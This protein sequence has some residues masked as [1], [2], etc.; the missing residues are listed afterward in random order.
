MPIFGNDRVG[1]YNINADDIK[2]IDDM[3][4]SGNTTEAV[5]YASKIVGI[6]PNVGRTL[7]WTESA[8]NPNAKSY[9]GAFGLA[10]LM[11]ST[12]KDL[13]VEISDPAQNLLGGLLYYK[14]MLHATGGDYVQ[15]YKGYQSGNPKIS[16]SA[17]DNFH[18]QGVKNF[19]SKLASLGVTGKADVGSTASSDNSL[20]QLY[21]QIN[22]GISDAVSKYS[23]QMIEI[24]NDWNKNI[25]NNV[26]PQMDA[27]FSEKEKA[28][29]DYAD[30][31]SKNKPPT[32]D[33][34]ARPKNA[35]QQFLKV[36]LPSILTLA[37]LISPGKYGYRVALASSL[38]DAIQK[39]D[40]TNYQILL[41]EWKNQMEN[42]KEEMQMRIAAIDTKLQRVQTDYSLDSQT[43]QTMLSFLQQQEKAALEAYKNLEDFAYKMTNLQS[44]D[45]YRKTRLE[46]DRQNA[47]SNRTRAQAALLSAEKK[48]SSSKTGSTG[49][50]TVLIRSEDKKDPIQ[51]TNDV[52]SLVSRGIGYAAQDLYQIVN[53]KQDYPTLDDIR[54]NWFN[55]NNPKDPNTVQGLVSQALDFGS[56]LTGIEISDNRKAEIIY[57]VFNDYVKANNPGIIAPSFMKHYILDV[58]IPAYQ[59]GYL[60]SFPEKDL[61]SIEKLIAVSSL[62]ESSDGVYVGNY[63]E[64]QQQQQ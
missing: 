49:S 5:N 52:I 54:K 46:I 34:V 28:L 14:G 23:G 3:V 59:A 29:S 9:A 61:Q 20:S 24:L 2:K 10:Q 33:E 45:E 63:S 30:K 57:K 55:P 15:A 50:S 13:G 6:D 39:R 17:L 47:E 40:L 12:A 31:I 4:A 22:A 26:K 36:T 38:W 62:L 1:K 60:A 56:Q 8:F 11:P 19:A 7:I 58:L 27:I 51:L 41:N 43:K 18:L 44:L 32:Y 42:M 64:Q 48:G 35:M 53:N 16:D 37:A 21:S 25:Q